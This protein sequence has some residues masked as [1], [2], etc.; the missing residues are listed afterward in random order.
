MKALKKWL[1]ILIL[2]A[3][4]RKQQVFSYETKKHDK[5][6]DIVIVQKYENNQVM[7]FTN[8][9]LTRKESLY[10]CPQNL[11]ENSNMTFFSTHLTSFGWKY[12][13]V[14]TYLHQSVQKY[15][16]NDP[17]CLGN[18]AKIYGSVYL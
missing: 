2:L 6:V 8:I 17:N 1:I 7:S 14:H 13:N 3:E 10:K 5:N 15:L 12:M 4:E 18:N 16:I 11:L 9:M